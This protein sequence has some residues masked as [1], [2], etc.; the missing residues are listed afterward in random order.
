LF[1][2]KINKL[3]INN[4][5]TFGGFYTCF[6]CET[7]TG[8]V[9][10]LVIFQDRP[11]FSHII[12]KGELPID[13]AENWSMLKNYRKRTTPVLVSYSKQVEHFPQGG[14]VFLQCFGNQF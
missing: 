4:K 12:Q 5:K 1:H 8:V 11:V 9:R 3:K 10:I 7:K 14:G 6:G 2:R 13:V